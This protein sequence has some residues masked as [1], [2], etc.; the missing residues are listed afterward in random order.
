MLDTILLVAILVVV[1]AILVSIK[2]GFNQ[3]IK[4]LQAI[5]DML[6]KKRTN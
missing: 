3:V 5:H 1:A 6:E 2:V 4:G